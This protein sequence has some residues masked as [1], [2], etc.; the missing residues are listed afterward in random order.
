LWITSRSDGPSVSASWATQKPAVKGVERR[1]RSG[2]DDRVWKR[3]RDALADLG[4]CQ[5]PGGVVS[6]QVHEHVPAAFRRAICV[7]VDDGS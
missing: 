2:V 7:G 5:V 3:K 4:E 6:D 1:H